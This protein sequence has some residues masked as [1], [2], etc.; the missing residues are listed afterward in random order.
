MCGGKAFSSWGE[1][2]AISNSWSCS[3]HSYPTLEWSWVTE[4][5][6]ISPLAMFIYDISQFWAIVVSTKFAKYHSEKEYSVGKQSKF[7]FKNASIGLPRLTPTQD[8]NSLYKIPVIKGITKYFVL[9]ECFIFWEQL[10]VILDRSQSFF[11]SVPQE[12]GRIFTAI[13][14]GKN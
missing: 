10:K 13:M 3:Y 1:S 9:C 4:P 12:K 14:L 8:Y 5:G 2:C 11:N 6:S 7:P